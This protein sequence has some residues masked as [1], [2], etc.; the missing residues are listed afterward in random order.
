VQFA[1][2]LKVSHRRDMSVETGSEFV[3]APVVWWSQFL[4]VGPEVPGSLPGD[5]RFAEKQGLWNGVYSAYLR[6]Y[7]N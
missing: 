2:E 4:A 1:S 5:T 7:L 3:T 6:S